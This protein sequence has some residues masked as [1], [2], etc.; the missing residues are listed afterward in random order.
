MH[1]LQLDLNQVDLATLIRDEVAK[2]KLL[3]KD[4]LAIFIEEQGSSAAIQGD[5]K[6]LGALLQKGLLFFQEVANHPICAISK[7]TL[8][9]PLGWLEAPKQLPA[10]QL[11]LSATDHLPSA[12]HFKARGCM[13]PR[14]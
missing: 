14:S 8:D 9:D 4:P 1:R 2:F 7:A 3:H 13:A 11:T 6:R 5:P 10:L 12:V